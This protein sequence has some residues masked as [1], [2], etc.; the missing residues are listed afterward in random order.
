MAKAIQGRRVLVVWD[1]ADN[2]VKV[3]VSYTVDSDIDTDCG[4]SNSF[5]YTDPISGSTTFA[6]ANTAIKNMIKQIEGIP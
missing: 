3:E 5:P 4:K 1:A 6:Q 2:I